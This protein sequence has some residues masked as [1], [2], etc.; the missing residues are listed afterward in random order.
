MKHVLR[1]WCTTYFLRLLSLSKLNVQLD[2]Q[3]HAWP[4]YTKNH[5]E[6]TNEIPTILSQE[7]PSFINEKA[8][9]YSATS[10][11]ARVVNQKNVSFRTRLG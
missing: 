11:V 2:E 4:K 9:K 10:I 1:Y 6:K 5:F 8:K 7:A 3:T